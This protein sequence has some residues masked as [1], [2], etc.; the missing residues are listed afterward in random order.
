MAV[1]NE[2]ET[3][4]FVWD[5]DCCNEAASF[6]ADPELR[7]VMRGVREDDAEDIVWV[8]NLYKLSCYWSHDSNSLY[9]EGAGNYTECSIFEN[10]SF[11]SLNPGQPG[12][13]RFVKLISKEE[14][15]DDIIIVKEIKP[16]F[17]VPLIDDL[18]H[19]RRGELLRNNDNIE[20]GEM[21]CGYLQCVD[22]NDIRYIDVTDHHCITLSQTP[23]DDD[24]I[25]LTPRDD[26][27]YQESF[28]YGTELR[29]DYSAGYGRKYFYKFYK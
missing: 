29:N 7:W 12:L 19:Y 23:D 3:Y 10:G 26:N 11:E 21:E 8:M 6:S 24:E 4:Y 14:L 17:I 15:T 2:P 18:I 20:W 1:N 13:Y 16:N 5:Q 27:I 22:H 9:L 25:Y 28:V